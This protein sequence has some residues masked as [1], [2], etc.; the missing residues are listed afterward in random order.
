MTNNIW[1]EVEGSR[2]HVVKSLKRY[3]RGREW[4]EDVIQTAMLKMVERSHQLQD[5]SKV[6]GWF[7]I[8]AHNVAK[9][10]MNRDKRFRELDFEQSHDPRVRSNFDM[11]DIELILTKGLDGKQLKVVWMRLVEGVSLVEIAKMYGWHYDTTKANYRHGWLKVSKDLLEYLK[12][13]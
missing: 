4:C 2:S 13:D 6:K 9:N 3:G 10:E 12:H 8:I 11:T 5:P 1:S 7:Y